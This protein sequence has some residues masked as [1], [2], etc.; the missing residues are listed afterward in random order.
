MYYVSVGCDFSIGMFDIS[1][2]CTFLKGD[3]RSHLI[4]GRMTYLLNIGHDFEN[5]GNGDFFGKCDII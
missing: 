4:K 1:E 2:E 5:M 3:C